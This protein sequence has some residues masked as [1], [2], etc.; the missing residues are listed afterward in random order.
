MGNAESVENHGLAILEVKF[1]SKD[2]PIWLR[3]PI[4]HKLPDG[5]V[6]G[7]ADLVESLDAML[8][9][10]GDSHI[11]LTSTHPESGAP[12]TVFLRAR[13]LDFISIFEEQAHAPSQPTS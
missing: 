10:G 5:E 8:E 1:A 3:V 4:G 12:F 13:N 11:Q 9:E 7:M 6:F 2:D